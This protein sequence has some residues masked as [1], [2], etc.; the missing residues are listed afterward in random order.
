MMDNNQNAKLNKDFQRETVINQ[1]IVATHEEFSR[2]ASDKN[3]D[4]MDRIAVSL[5][6][7]HV[8]LCALAR[9]VFI[10]RGSC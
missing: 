3:L 1:A 10:I 7:F 8:N 9:G 4:R 6:L 5:A 2:L